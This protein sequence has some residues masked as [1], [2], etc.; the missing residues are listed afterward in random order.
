MNQ[1][2]DDDSDAKGGSNP[3]W[4]SVQCEKPPSPCKEFNGWRKSWAGAHVSIGLGGNAYGAVV[5]DWPTCKWLCEEQL[6]C[7]QAVFHKNSRAC[8]G[9]NQARDDDSDAKGGSN[10]DWISVQCEKPR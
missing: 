1:A 10:P 3:D 9:M 8:Y 6:D 7:K 5:A 2:R 4:I